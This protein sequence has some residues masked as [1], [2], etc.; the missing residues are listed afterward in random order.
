MKKCLHF[1]LLLAFYCLL[2]NNAFAQCT[3]VAV[4]KTNSIKVYAH[5]M[6][7][8]IGP[9]N[10]DATSTGYSWGS[11][12]TANGGGADPN[13]FS[14][15][16]NYVGASVSVRN[17][18]AHYHPLIGPYD[19]Q[20]PYVIEDHFLLMKLA[21]IDGIMID[22]Y[23]L[24]NNGASDAGVNQNNTAAMIAN[25]GKYGLKY[26]LVMEDA[27]WNGSPTS[28]GAHN[29]GTFAAT[30]YFTDAN[31]IK[32]GDMRG[33][34]DPN[35]GAPLVAVFG[36][37]QFKQPGQWSSI[38]GSGNTKA[39]LP[40]YGQAAQI[41]TDAGGTFVWP[42]PQATKTMGANAW[43]TDNSSYYD[44]TYY[45]GGAPNLRNNK[46][47]SNTVLGNNVILGSAYPGF[48]DFY[49]G[50]GANA[51][52]FIPRNA[53]AGGNPTAGASTLSTML[54]LCQANK[55]EIDGIQIATWNDFSEG[56]VIEPTVEYGFQSL[57][58]IQQFTGVSFVEKDL[59]YVDTLF[60]LRKQYS[61]NPTM[62]T[63]LNQASC[64]FAQANVTAAESILSCIVKTGSTGCSANSGPS[65]TGGT[66]SVT[67]NNALSY[68]I[69]ATSSNG[70]VTGYGATG[71]VPGLSVN[72]STGVISGTPVNVGIDTITVSATDS[73]GT[74][75][76]VVY[77]T[78]K[79][80]TSELPYQGTIAQIP[81]TIQAEN[82]DWGGQ[83]VAYNDNDATNNGFAYRPGEG[84]DIEPC[85][86][87][88]L[89]YDVG[90]TNA[91]E[92]MQYQVNV[93][94]AGTYTLTGRVA[95]GAGTAT[96]KFRVLLGT[97]VI[98]TL[99]VPNTG[100]WGT[101]QTTVAVTTPSL[102]T[103]QQTLKI[104][105]DS[106]D[107]NI[108][109]ITFTLTAAVAPV[110]SSAGTAT[111]TQG[112]AF[113]GYTVTAT[114]SPTSYA[115]TGLPTGLSI[116]TSTGVISGTPTVNGTF[117]VSVS[118]T[119]T[120][121]TGSK[122]VSFTINPPAPSVST[123]A[124]AG[125]VGTP[126]TYTIS[127]TNSPTSYTA[128]PLPAGLT[129]DPAT[130]I[131]SGIPTAV[132]TT[133]TTI[134]ATNAGGAGTGTVTI[135]ITAAK[136]AV[137]TNSASGTVG[138][139]FS[140]TIS[141]TN[142]PTSYTATPLP[143]GLTFNSSTGIIS[144]TPTAV[145][146]TAVNITATNVTGTG[147]GTVTITIVNPPAPSITSSSSASGIVGTV[148]TGYT[149]TATNSPTSYSVTGTLPPGLTLSG[150]VISGTPTASG[151]YPVTI[152]ATN[153]GGT[154]S[155][156]LT[157]TVTLPPAPA[158]TSS[159]TA[160]ATVNTAFSYTITATNSPTSYSATGLP[161]GLSI[162]TSTGIISGT[163]TVVAT[164]TITIG[165][166]NLGGT[167][168]ATLTLT[169]S[170]IPIPVITS[171]FTAG[172]TVAS[173]FTTYT[174]TASNS[175]TS[176]AV[177]GTLPPGLTF[178][179]STIT[180]TPTVAGTYVDTVKAT[181]AGG[182][183]IH[184]LTIT[185]AALPSCGTSMIVNALSAPTIDGTIDGVWS[186][187]P[188]NN[189]NKTISGTIQT[190][191]T[192]QAMY[193]ATNLY[194]LVQ[195]TDA[196]RSSVGTNVYDQDGVELFLSG[197]NNK[198]NAYI[199]TD[200]QY[201]FNWN[202]AAT[203]ANITGTNNTTTGISYA[204]P[205]GGAG[206]ILEVSIP[207]ATIGGP[208]PFNGKQLGFDININDQQNNAGAREATAGWN[209]TAT[210]DF[211]NPASMG[212]TTLTVCNSAPPVPV[213]SSNTA[214]GAVGTAFNY[215]INATNAPISYAATGLPGGLS[216]NTST[217]VI[218]GTPI[219]AGGPTTVNISATNAGGTGTG[220]VS[221][222]INPAQPV[223]SSN[224]ATGTVGTAFNYTI[225]ATNA[226]TSYAATGLPSGLSINTSTGVISG[227]PTIAGGPTTVNISATNAGGTGTGTVSITINPA[228]PVV[229]S[230]T[231]IGTVGTA[232]SYTISATNAPASYTATGL[233]SG[234]S[235][236]TSTGLISGTP[237]TAGGPTTVNISATNAGG[238]GT[239][240]VSITINPAQPVVSSN[241]AI[242]TVGTAFSYT[243]SATN[244]PTSYAATGL[245]AGL[246]INTS[247]GVISGT[248][249]IAGGPTTV[250][251]SA[252]NAGGTG[253]GTVSITINPAQP[254]VSSN[255]A[256]GTLGAVF[257]YT[258][259][260]TNA[261]TSY[262]ATGLPAG[263]SINTST[264]VISGTPTTAGGPT[265]VNISATNAGGTGTGTVSIT[266][267]P[268]QPVVSSNTAIG[269]VGAV[270]SYT[271]SAT[272]APTSYTATGLPAGL[273][274][275]T[276][277][278]VIS[279]TPTAAGGPTTVNISATNAGG[280][281]TGTVSI[282]INPA[283]PIVSSN[284]A[285]GTVGTVFSY[286]I[287]A[288]N[289]PT[290]YTA[291]G[292][293]GGLS[294]NTSTGVISGTP[295]TAGGPTIVNI[296]ATNASGTGTGTVSITINPVAVPAP[297]VTSNIAIGTVG[298][299]FSYTISAT[300]SPTSYAAT[301]LPAGLSINITTGIISG[302]P[303][304]VGG[305]TTVNIS[306]TNSGG[307]GIGT[308][309]ITI[310]PAQPVVSSNTANGT[311]GTVFSYTISAT[312][313][314]TSYTATG[315]PGGL[316]I[317][318]STGVISGTPTITGGP[319]IVN[320]S[321]T[322]AGGTG[323]G[324]VSVTINPAQPVVSSN[325]ATG[326]V[327]TAFTYTISATGTPT[328]YA[329]TGLPAGLSINTST[330]VISGTPT[331]AGGPTTVN[332]SATN[333][334]GT[335]TGTV[336]ITINPAQPV[337]S[338]NTAIGTVG[339]AF[340]YTI[341]ATNAPTSYAATGLPAG[342]SINTST[343]VISGTPT[344]AGG[345]TTV[346]ISATN[347]GGTGT[348]TVSVTINPAQP[349][350]TSNIA[351]G[352]VGTAF[353]Y[354]IS[355]TGTPIS[356]TATGLPAGLSINTATG[357][358]SGI[359]TTVGGP[360]IVN[361]SA[362]NA[363]GIGTGTV[364]ITINP[365]AV[366]A[367][368]VTSNIA[369]GTA[370]TVFSYTISATNSPTSYAA[371]G[372]PSG[373]SINISTGVISGTP[374]TAGGPTTVNISATNSGGTGTGTVSI[375][376]NPAQPVVSSNTAIGTVGTAFSYT[377]SATNSPTGY[378]ATG[379]PAGL[380]INTSTGVISGTPTAAGG[381]T[382][383]NISA[384]NAGGTGTG[385]VSVTINPAQP[386]VSSN[387]A[388][389]TVGIAFSYTISATNSPTSYSSTTL[390]A[391][392][393]INTSTGV[394]NGTPTAAGSTN[395]TV[396]ATNAGG[397]G[398][399]II[400]ITISAALP[401]VPV[402]SAAT[403]SGT[404]GT[405]FSYSV[406]ATNSPTSYS[407]TTLPAGLT[408]NTTT[409]VISGIP[410]AVG[411]TIVTVTATNAGGSGSNIITI[412][413]SAALPPAPVVTTATKSGTVG[414]SFSYSVIATNSPT[415]Y[416]STALPAGLTLNATTG[417]I[418]GTPTAVGSTNVTVTATNAGGSG[419]NIIAINI[420]AA[421]PP[422][423]V[424]TT[425]TKSG[426]VGTSF[427]YSVIATN[428]PTSYSSTTLPA[429]LT[430]NTTTGVISGTPTAVGS[431]NVTVT[432][433]NAGGSGSNIIT[434][435]ISAALPP[436]PVVGGNG[437]A[438]GVVGTGFIYAITAS[439]SPTSYSATPLPAGLT[440]NPTTGVI[441]GTPTVAGSTV[442][443][444]T[445]TNAGGTSQPNI[446]VIDVTAPQAPVITS[447]T[448]ETTVEGEEFSYIIDADNAPTSY[449]AVGL[450]NG[451]TINSATGEIT[452]TSIVSGL[453][454]VIIEATNAVGTGS[455]ILMLTV[456]PDASHTPG[457][458][459]PF[460]GPNPVTA[461]QFN[462][463]L[464]GWTDTEVNC[465]IYNFLGMLMQ[466]ETN[467]AVGTISLTPNQGPAYYG[468]GVTINVPNLI[469]GDYI[470]VL[471][472]KSNNKVVKK[473]TVRQ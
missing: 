170:N 111:G 321:A 90:W 320:I 289:A 139:A 137:T 424:V 258:I 66:A 197:T 3:P 23:G 338:S 389:G 228:Q 177:S 246:S 204:I 416:S 371:T 164:S 441:S 434:I 84:V 206:Y 458:L 302:T 49:G 286:T 81:G 383:V 178:S 406:V 412:N 51:D 118:A 56:T 222:T 307:T 224:T 103:G 303:T 86:D 257:S 268:A 159:L 437:S 270:F 242:G 93:N 427:N 226:P 173:I 33:S 456:T 156:P 141:A 473:F 231:A 273:S 63:L 229:S 364:S 353:T 5:Y 143:A 415:S 404:V 459:P 114:N 136:P 236:N 408:L 266:I 330:G 346:N 44:G 108:N 315:L 119:N 362:T 203:T 213:V 421:L 312:N 304:T 354:T 439:H 88:G 154:D 368:V 60:R 448:A 1:S 25:I 299:A 210:D 292:L 254:V 278:G 148:F 189:I 67:V 24:A 356:Y 72:T 440:L 15:V 398:S 101:F 409:G 428:S 396:T 110:I 2:I 310:N 334:G 153:I 295:I 21:G 287:S 243:I 296:S 367:P 399:G 196:N 220:T 234:L 211:N 471:R 26:G 92:W 419:S 53:V 219:A 175:P 144:G 132:V 253:T 297:V 386:V 34:G 314:P 77:L 41:G 293:P 472:N 208:A 349:V 325:T 261:P 322:N 309:S 185:I 460:L 87:T 227:T 355:A 221:I 463:T 235:I 352:T 259:S 89:G 397:S 169:V 10:P 76:A 4:T 466:Q 74:T 423:P 339:T 232:F 58:T 238:T 40:L 345:P 123:N 133:S 215:T 62:Q 436:V 381:P 42:Y 172:G 27:A 363:T 385:T 39:F 264:G 209:G 430:L 73:K 447:D 186:S 145:A 380:S 336:S 311:V 329:A 361:I 420:S 340:S 251:I 22:W 247:T 255:T 327:G 102:T 125:S 82:F 280:T 117:S 391:G 285:N 429:G 70:G 183:G 174:I 99:T 358:I 59:R 245:P 284:I 19:E 382:T 130:G 68:S 57:V 161:A 96:K 109:Y 187:A 342:L 79:Q 31:Y 212:T 8:F 225:S 9:T 442:V 384:T 233:P 36:P 269:T 407:S 446:L 50:G 378:A 30:N 405:A 200:H 241:T 129:L 333:S 343:G 300:N 348:G 80:P 313:A 105:L 240:T 260:A 61:T 142:S 78:I 288:T 344:T 393:S 171:A 223:V 276:S 457:T 147:T 13:S 166:T 11:H 237:T 45:T 294:I 20:D 417:V 252:T 54:N 149:I 46:K 124:A 69:S 372:L 184:I 400:T 318:T 470:I 167:T 104:A 162:N 305:P 181:N 468:P 249:T 122:T 98:G 202:V 146:T 217:G 106:G 335:G 271:I 262:A 121:G 379:L 35:A 467:I 291:T 38:L 445:A 453:Y 461:K 47:E 199:G 425:A 263:L 127:A 116:N 6:P 376:I 239:G 332:I 316:S 365:V 377:I 454:H 401:P 155:K 370:G 207:W 359:P 369:I 115:A 317:N 94:T 431:T 410:T 402:V 18:D 422:A 131:I 112:S 392:L 411:S 120:G 350:I 290:S 341:S 14:T 218:S 455:K 140:Y 413:I 17:I 179:G 160:S 100:G 274:I 388:I 12:W 462:V 214:I 248:P 128:T 452:G 29:N 83:G 16:T 308:V 357:V 438:D 319:T 337:V 418:S 97:T 163:P 403:K 347:S 281:G 351:N 95:T 37:Q 52:G 275:N 205:T 301:G 277:T 91:G 150:N 176:Y 435:N 64:Y 328:S 135:T 152:N 387:T 444:I 443:K 192:W 43:Y 158:I 465:E 85:G 267:N 272:N 71:L 180:G 157:I 201:R 282:T 151:T 7:W 194:V 191:S 394:I 244:A 48:N 75:T 216:I 198:T 449:N 375:T 230:N 414:T 138:T 426:T 195:V 283:Q 250:N 450:P 107:F 374:T 32:L 188:K 55:S 324:T 265:T 306:A 256:I 360:T 464:P 168:T 165:A 433:T 113:T 65:I 190:G 331:T 432:A 134:T 182:T 390:P 193:D 451:L 28:G 323:T 126:F 279:G 373:L 395:V 326:E 298:A 366:P 469:G